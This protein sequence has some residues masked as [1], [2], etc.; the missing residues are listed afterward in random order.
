M[1]QSTVM[2]DFL[3]GYRGV[4]VFENF[5]QF[6]NVFLPHENKKLEF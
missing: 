5:G 6:S 3:P 4:I 2:L 1:Q